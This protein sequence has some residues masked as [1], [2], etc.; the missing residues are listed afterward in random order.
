M[1][2]HVLPCCMVSSLYI[3]HLPLFLFFQ[4]RFMYTTMQILLWWK[5][6]KSTSLRCLLYGITLNPIDKSYSIFEIRC[7]LTTS[8]RF[9]AYACYLFFS[10]M[11]NRGAGVDPREKQVIIT[12]KCE[13][14]VW[15]L[16]RSCVQNSINNIII[17]RR[18]QMDTHASWP[19]YPCVSINV[20]C[21]H[22]FKV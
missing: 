2:I 18:I 1:C 17:R 12:Y 15:T 4:G 19:C 5:H 13:R 8:A 21:V 10:F 22:M 16:T 14:W 9:Y 11:Q 3:F 20:D 7:K 6:L